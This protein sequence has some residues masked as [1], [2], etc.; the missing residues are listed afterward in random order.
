MVMLVV[1][2]MA[3]VVTAKA[4]DLVLRW[5]QIA[6]QTA[7]ATNP[8]NQAR[9]GAIVQLAVFE[10]VNA[11]TKDY[12]PYLNPPTVAPPGTSAEAAAIIA[13]H[14]VL[15]TFFPAA[16][17]ALDAAR[18]LDLAAIPN[19]S[20]KTNG[21]AVGAAAANAMIAL[22]A[23][24][25]SSPLTTIIPTSTN[26]GD[27]QLTTGCAAAMFYNWQNVTPFGIADISD[28]LLDPPPSLASNRVAKDYFE[29]NL[30][31][32]A[33]S[34]ARPLDRTE[35]V[36][37]YAA[38]SPSFALSA[39]TRQIS[40]AKRTSL[41]GNARALALL[42]M[43]INDALIASYMNK[44]HYNRWR[45]ET[46]IRNGA[47]DGNDKTDGNPGFTTF[48]PTPCFPSYPSNHAS[49]TNGGLEVMR[50]LFG[51]A[52]FDITISNNVPALG[53]L[54]A[55]V[56]T[57]HYTQLNEIADDVDDARVYGGIHWRYDQDAGNVLGRAVATEIVKTR[58]RPV[59]P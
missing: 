55:T 48:I 52:G 51:A 13:A 49:G 56:I 53:S 39:A 38:T 7:T 15:A 47:S 59:H 25:G 31:G 24:D 45:P 14:N 17:A 12:E 8:F 42:Q 16:S 43:G 21:I 18:D 32:T 33:T 46:G 20:A 27:Y 4:D 2:L 30:V 40:A 44:Y 28:F 11:V 58:L 26:A 37:L 34:T 54:P 5:N 22:R 10:A 19:G 41:S 35:V 1:G 23:A 36:R 57:K 3:G 50:R 9:V 6:A 29:V